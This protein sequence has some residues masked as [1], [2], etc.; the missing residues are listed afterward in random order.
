MTRFCT[1]CGSANLDAARFC[2]VCGTPV[3]AP[4]P[5]APPAAIGP[6]R[7]KRGTIMAIGAISVA[8]LVA[9]SGLAY[10]LTPESPSEAS[11][12]RAIDRYLTANPAAVEARVCLDN[13]R[14]QQETIR[15]A[16]YDR[17]TRKWMDALVQS[18]LYAAPKTEK[19]G[20]YFV[21]TQFAYGLTEDGRNAIRN[22]KLCLG[23]GLR[24][25]SVSGFDTVR[26]SDDE[27]VALAR[28]TAEIRNEAAWLGK[29]PSRTEV[30]GLSDRQLI[31][32]SMPVA[33]IDG[34]WQVDPEAES[35]PQRTRKQD[36]Q[37]APKTVATNSFF[38]TIK[39]WFTFSANPLTG[40]WRD[41][42][43]LVA[44]EFTNDYVIEGRNKIAARYEVEG[45]MIK[46]IPTDAPQNAFVVQ[47]NDK[48][49]ALIDLGLMSVKLHRME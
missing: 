41:D 3:K 33:L 49:S 20:S 45:E 44:F 17:R 9:G 32:M 2:E 38:S 34:K 48:N 22:N 18:G 31:T 21:Q 23:E 36:R 27:S 40:K 35:H 7:P 39:Q 5:K 46:V 1:Q 30:L 13:M 14:Y 11:F 29:S 43:G 16:E 24:I 28:A 47:M 25:K 6:T 4:V 19:I 42:T 10:W 15:V 26:K 37:A 8:V 12:S